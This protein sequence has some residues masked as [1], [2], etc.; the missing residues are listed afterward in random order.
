MS[1]AEPLEGWTASHELAWEDP[2]AVYQ[3]WISKAVRH[4]AVEDSKSAELCPW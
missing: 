4:S 2:S 3:S 1:F